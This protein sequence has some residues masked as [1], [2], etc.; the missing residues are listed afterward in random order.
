M[1]EPGCSFPTLRSI[2]YNSVHKPEYVFPSLG[3]FHRCTQSFFFIEMWS[4]FTAW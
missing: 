2:T 3:L 4:T 1:Q